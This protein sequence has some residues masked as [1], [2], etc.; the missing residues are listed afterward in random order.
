[1]N[2]LHQDL[3]SA[4]AVPRGLIIV[5][6]PTG[7]GKTTAIEG[8][9]AD[10]N[11]PRGVIFCGDVRDLEAA[12]EAVRLA[13]SQVVV[14]VLRIPRASG[15]FCRLIDMTIPADDVVDVARVAFTTRLFRSPS[16]LLLHERLMVTDSTRALIL[17]GA[18]PDLIHSQA[19]AEGM[20]SLREVGLA[21]VFAGRLTREAV[22]EMTMED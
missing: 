5:T 12:R 1:M 17:S 18:D 6:G 20:R 10:P 7:H 21:Y 4:L 2:D 22:V 15:A 13:H 11:C 8:V 14:A 3:L 16:M 19:I 9:L